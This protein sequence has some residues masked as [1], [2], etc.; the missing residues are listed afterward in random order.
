MLVRENCVWGL[1]LRFRSCHLDLDFEAVDLPDFIVGS[2]SPISERGSSTATASEPQGHASGLHRSQA[3]RGRRAHQASCFSSLF[4]SATGFLQRASGKEEK[5][6][7]KDEREV[8]EGELKEIS[9]LET[10]SKGRGSR[11]LK[12][13]GLNPLPRRWWL[14][15]LLEGV[16]RGLL[17][18]APSSY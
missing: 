1:R 3:I 12:D 18:G 14:Q 9:Q 2:S 15:S 17:N 5:R 13:L 4:P 11:S 8:E 6:R 7:K 10:T 16:G